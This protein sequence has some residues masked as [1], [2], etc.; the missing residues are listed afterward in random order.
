MV[1][2]STHSGDLTAIYH[3]HTEPARA[4]GFHAA[5]W[6]PE[7]FAAHNA[8]LSRARTEVSAKG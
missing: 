7:V 5:Y 3:G 6:L 2:S 8:L 1:T 4:C